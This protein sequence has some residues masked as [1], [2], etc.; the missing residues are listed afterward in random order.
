MLSWPW[1]AGWIHTEMSVLHQELNLDMVAHLSTNRARRR[2]TLL[3]EANALTTT[4]DHQPRYC[5]HGM[6]VNRQQQDGQPAH[7]MPLAAYCCQLR[8]KIIV[9]KFGGNDVPRCQEQV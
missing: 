8:H 1:V 2:L 9:S 7:L 6:R 3:I 5:V 4:Q